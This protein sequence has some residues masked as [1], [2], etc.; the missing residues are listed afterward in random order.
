MDDN[1]CEGEAMDW[2]HLLAS[3]TGTVDHALLLRHEYLA[4]E[5]RILR[6]QSKG[7]VR[8]TDRA[9]KTLAELGQQ[10]GK[11]ALQAGAT[12]VK[13]DTML[14]WHCKLVAQKCDSSQHRKAQGRPMI[15]HELEA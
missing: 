14:A 9:R 12:I 1:R 8:L 11:Q 6:N 2:K 5:N 7:R 15:D 4:T 3:I 13:P 10:L